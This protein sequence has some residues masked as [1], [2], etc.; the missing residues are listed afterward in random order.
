VYKRQTLDD[1]LDRMAHTP[2][3]L[4]GIREPEQTWI[5]VDTDAVWQ[6]HGA[7]MF[8]RAA[9]TPF[10]D[11]TLRGRVEAVTLRGVEVYRGGISYAVAGAG[12]NLA[13]AH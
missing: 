5:E 11:W 3:R 1:V 8:S 10:E 7:Q 13:A 9:W 4:F 12:R 2:R 6:P